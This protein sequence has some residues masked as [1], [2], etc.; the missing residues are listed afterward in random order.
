VN[1]ETLAIVPQ[2]NDSIRQVRGVV[3]KTANSSESGEM[4][5][6]LTIRPAVNGDEAVLVRLNQFVQELHVANAGSTFRRADDTEL[7]AWFRAMFDKPDVRI[8]VAEMDHAPVGYVM[9]SHNERLE[10]PYRYARRCHD[11]DAIAVLPQWQR[12]GIGRALVGKVFEEARAASVE[13]V[14]LSSWSFNQSAHEAFHRLGFAPK[15][16][17][18]VATVAIIE[19]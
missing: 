1:Q 2:P 6:S 16:V 15:W 11:I 3:S 9:V 19:T 18:F 7:A 12:R 10:S 8:W 13:E 4:S 17:R 14:E 5:M